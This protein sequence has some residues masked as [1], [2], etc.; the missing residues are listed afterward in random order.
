MLSMGWYPGV[1]SSAWLIVAVI[2]MS[3]PQVTTQNDNKGYRLPTF[4]FVS[5]Q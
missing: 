4:Q 2:V 1:V 3:V 5:R